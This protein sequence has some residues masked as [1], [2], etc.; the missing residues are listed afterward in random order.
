[1]A[2]IFAQALQI[3]GDV[4][5]RDHVEHDMHS[6]TAGDRLHCLDKVRAVVIDRMVGAEGFG[7]VAFGVRAAGNDNL[8]PV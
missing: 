2:S 7:G 4:A 5:A 8:Q 1:M 3:A 6:G